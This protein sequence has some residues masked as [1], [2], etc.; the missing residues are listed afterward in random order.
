LDDN[1]RQKL[2]AK[3]KERAKDDI[4]SLMKYVEGGGVDIDNKSTLSL[5][6]G[7]YSSDS[8]LLEQIQ[9]RHK[10]ILSELAQ[11]AST[12]WSVDENEVT[13]IPPE[14]L[15]R[16]GISPFTIPSDLVG[17]VKVRSF[18]QEIRRVAE[19]VLVALDRAFGKATNISEILAHSHTW[20]FQE[21]KI[22]DPKRTCINPDEDRG[23]LEGSSFN[24]CE[25]WMTDHEITLQPIVRDIG[26]EWYC[27]ATLNIDDISH[28][29]PQEWPETID[30]QSLEPCGLWGPELV[31]F[32]NTEPTSAIRARF[33]RPGATPAILFRW[34]QSDVDG[35]EDDDIRECLDVGLH[36][37]TSYDIR[38]GSRHTLE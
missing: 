16:M 28:V 19:L 20:Q 13:E 11:R 7:E 25:K 33:S 29:R 5:P 34:S 38:C 2:F 14:T 3:S 32:P 12:V 37:V 36:I 17:S 27:V 30:Q 10:L 31:R 9:D 1:D 4:Q 22:T 6:P 24:D 26:G 23:V 35:L 18:R 15:E 21:G 8:D